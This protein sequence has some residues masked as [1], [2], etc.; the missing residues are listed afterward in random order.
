[1]IDYT[2][3]RFIPEVKGTIYLE[4][5]HRYSAI[6]SIVQNKMVL[7]IA[8]GE[9]YGSHLLSANAQNVI[10]VDISEQTIKHAKEKYV[11][12]NLSFKQGSAS[13][14]PIED[15]SIDVVVSFETI[16]HHNL[17]DEMMSEIRRVLKPNGTL[18]MS[19]PDKV[20][21]NKTLPEPNKFHVK[22]LNF[23]EFKSL[24]N[25]NFKHSE[26]FFQKLV[27]GSLLC[28]ETS[29]G[30]NFMSDSGETSTY[31]SMNP[32]Y[33]LCIAS[34]E[35]IP[36]SISAS[37]T[38]FFDGTNVYLEALKKNQETIDRIHASKTWKIGRFILSPFSIFKK[39]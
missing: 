3:E 7:D 12:S 38:S 31:S 4:H 37:V 16:E 33:D 6:R 2:G 23:S 20:N 1:M 22:E 34:N 14:M 32:I 11:N 27:Y 28:Q 10:G 9:G 19:S 39:K 17:H 5:Y 29:S 15:N 8:C 35:P 25:K 36:A 18:I 26:F 30:F 13:E 24:I 21:Y